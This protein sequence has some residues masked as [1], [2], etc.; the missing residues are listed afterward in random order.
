MSEVTAEQF[1]RWIDQAMP[2]AKL[3]NSGLSGRPGGQ[4]DVTEFCKRLDPGFSNG[5]LG[6]NGGMDP[7]WNDVQPPTPKVLTV[8]EYEAYKR[9]IKHNLRRF[10]REAKGFPAKLKE[11]V[12]FKVHDRIFGWLLEPNLTFSD[13]GSGS[14]ASLFD[15]GILRER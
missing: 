12:R 2:G 9:K 11:R 15:E 4:I 3:M 8:T 1:Q 14:D 6:S 13:Y 5:R 10:E 7:V